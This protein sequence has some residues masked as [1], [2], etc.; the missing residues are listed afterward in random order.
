MSILKQ[1]IIITIFSVPSLGASG[2]A[3]IS[4][5]KSL[6]LEGVCKVIAAAEAYAK[7]HISAGEQSQSSMMAVTL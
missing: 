1:L 5:K 3:P 4:E 2:L 6:T 7:E